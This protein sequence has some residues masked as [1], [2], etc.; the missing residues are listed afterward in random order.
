MMNYEIDFIGV[1]EESSKDAAA[2]CLRFYSQELGR[3]VIIVYDGGFAVHGK[4]MV[5]LIK[6][7]Y[8]DEKFPYIDIV[9]CSHSDDDHASGLSEIFDACFVG[10]L[11]VNRPWLYASELYKKIKDKR[12]TIDSL[13][14]ELKETYSAI[15]ELETK[16]LEQDTKIHEGFQ[17]KV[18]SYVP[19]WILSPTREFFIQQVIE[20][21]KTPLQ[22]DASISFFKKAFETIRDTIKD[23]WNKD[24]I[25]E[26]ESTTPENE[27]SIVI[28]G[29][30]AEEGSFLLTGDAGVQALTEAADYADFMGISLSSVKFYQ[31]PHHGGRHNVSPSVL[32]RIVGSIQPSGTTPNKSAFVSV[33]KNSDHP[34]KMVVN[35]Y[36]RRGVKVFE[37]RTSSKWHHRGT[38]ERDAYNT[39]TPLEFSEYV[40]SWD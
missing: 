2:T 20:S 32:N 36:I 16:A 9:I 10:H 6:K 18:L 40:E 25:R 29:D 24:A 31:I 4:A 28:Y 39:A 12:K 1:N 34:K 5:K 38:P 27:T 22:E 33:A 30:M 19:L 8:T 35:A 14:R 23:Y 15:A 17:G 7:Y 3:Y 37:A 11:I 13:E 21:S 26:G